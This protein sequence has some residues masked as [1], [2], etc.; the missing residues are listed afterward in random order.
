MNKSKIYISLL[1]IVLV[2]SSCTMYQSTI[3]QANVQAQ[4][5]VSM[6]DVEYLKDAT[7]TA[8][9]SYVVGLPIGGTKYKQVAVSNM[10][11]GII[12]V[13]IRSRGY[14]N[15]LYNAMKSIPDADFIMPVSMEIVSDRMFLGREDSVIV[16]VKAFKLK[17][18]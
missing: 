18:Q 12:G 2:F 8:I 17:D 10:A 1:G 4:L 13:N 3:P 14:N 7:G 16:K 6:D 5:N 9:Q 15:A 11:T